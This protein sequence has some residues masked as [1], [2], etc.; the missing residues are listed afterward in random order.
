MLKVELHAH[1]AD[2]R[3]ERIPHTAIDLIDRAA[4]CGYQALAIT[5]HER[6]LDVRPLLPRARE[7]GLV[8]IPG[9]ECS[10]EGKHVLLINFPAEAEQ[11]RSFDD[12]ARLKGRSAGLVVA[13]HPFFPTSRCLGRLLDRYADLVDAVEFNAMYTVGLN[14]NTR[15]VRWATRHGKPLVGNCDI[16]RLSQLG[17]T[18]SLVDAE[19]DPDA[20]CA[21]IRGGRVQVQTQPLPWRTAVVT[22]AKIVA[23]G[24]QRPRCAAPPESTR[25]GAPST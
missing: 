15:A 19:P 9:I 16:H 21:A 10:I 25:R 22:F 13:P 20:I 24:V 8:L 4:E 12:I 7:R 18:F 11:A 14:F 17:T 2:D 5:L 23:G 6:Q 3:H 1:T